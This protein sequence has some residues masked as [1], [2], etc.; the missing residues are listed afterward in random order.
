[1]GPARNRSSSCRTSW[2][3]TLQERRPAARDLAA[4]GNHS[5]Q[6]PQQA[7]IEALHQDAEAQFGA[8]LITGDIEE[9]QSRDPC[10]LEE[11]SNS[12]NRSNQRSRPPP[13]RAQADLPPSVTRRTAKPR[14]PVRKFCREQGFDVA[15]PAFEGDA[16]AVRKA[17]SSCWPLATPSSCSTGPATRHGSAPSTT[18]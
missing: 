8:D 14:V 16:S 10:H 17:T 1:M 18:S 2:P 4:A 15:L 12:R 6:A 11:D 13:D 3:C 7:F 5:A 9:L